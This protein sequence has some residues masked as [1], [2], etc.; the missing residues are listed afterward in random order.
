MADD[1]TRPLFRSFNAVTNPSRTF[2][3]LSDILNSISTIG[4]LLPT[5]TRTMNFRVT[6]RDNRAAGG[7]VNSDAM[8][9]NVTSTAG[10]FVVTSPNTPLVWTGGTTETVTWNVAGTSTA[11]VN[12][13]NVN[14][15]LST[16]GG[17]TFPIVLVT[18]APNDGSQ[19]ISV[20]NVSTTVARVR[21]EAVG[22]VFFDVSNANFTVVQGSG[23]GGVN[24][25]GLYNPAASSFFLRNSNS[26]GV[27]NLSF[28][29]GPPGAG[30]L[31]LTGDWDGDGDDTIGLYNPS[32]S[33][34]FLRNANSSGVADISF[35]FGPAAG[36]L[37]LAGD[38]NGDGTDTIG[39]YNPATSTFFLKNSNSSGV[40]DVSFAYG[41]AGAGWVPIV[42]DWDGNGT[43]TIGLY[44]PAAG[45]FFLRNSNTTGVADVSFAYGPGGVGWKPLVG[46]WDG[47]GVDTIGLYNPSASG[48]FLRNT[49]STGVANVSFAYGPAGAGWTPLV[50]DWDGL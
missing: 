34:F 17:S 11:P 50:G 37:P 27:A 6:A 33:T 15:T 48:F 42:G 45:T 49:N 47:D 20:P 28:A 26:S 3:K 31:P 35:A 32:A 24:T 43:D 13:A 10:P 44:N 5:T 8:V 12:C 46:D 23:G 41:P 29:Y 39:L 21:V 19:T 22:N 38:W 36:W 4:E 14:I 18:N 16:D 40:A 2:P 30:W 9:L 7:G 25:P 1:G